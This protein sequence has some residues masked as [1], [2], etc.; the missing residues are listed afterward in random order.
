MAPPNHKN[1][2]FYSKDSLIDLYKESSDDFNSYTLISSKNLKFW[3]MFS[4]Q[5]ISALISVQ[6]SLKN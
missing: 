6:S 4:N 5:W 1:S 2:L 3:Y